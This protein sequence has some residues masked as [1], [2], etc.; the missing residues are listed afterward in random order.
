LRAVLFEAAVMT[1]MLAAKVVSA[2]VLRWR[3]AVATMPVVALVPV[4]VILRVERLVVVTSRVAIPDILLS[5][6]LVS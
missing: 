5:Q 1:G 4:R 2:V 3:V 6:I